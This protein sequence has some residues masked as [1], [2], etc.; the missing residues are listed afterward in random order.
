MTYTMI[1]ILFKAL[2]FYSL[3][4]IIRQCIWGFKIYKSVTNAKKKNKR[5]RQEEEGKGV[6]EAEY[7][8]IRED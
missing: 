4:V 5:P 2:L 3:F 1:A 6:I 7:K 8:V